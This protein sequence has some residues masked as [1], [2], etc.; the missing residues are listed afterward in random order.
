M[1]PFLPSKKILL[2][3]PPFYRFFNYERWHYPSTLTLVGTYLSKLGHDVG[4][5][6]ADA[7]SLNCKSL[8]RSEV[9]NNYPLYENALKN[10]EHPVWREVYE[11][12]KEFQPDIVGMTSI[13]A[14]I[15]S[16]NFI[17][18]LV[19][20]L[21]D[22]KVKII[23]GGPHA[24]GM[25][26]MYPDYN[27]G[28][29]YD[30]IITHIPNLVDQT[31]NKKLIM[32]IDR[33]SPENLSSILTIAGCP[34]KCTFC[35]RSFD[36]TFVYRN[37]PSVREELEEI[38]IE[39]GSTSVYI[40]DDCFF[41]HTTRFNEISEILKEVGLEFRAGSRIMALTQQKIERFINNGGIRISVGVESGSQQILD[42]VKK[43]L[44]IK[45]IIKHTKW[46][47]DLGVPWSAFIIV[48]FPFETLEELKLTEELIYTIGPTFASINRFAPYPGTEIY[49]KYFINAQIRFRDLF[50]LNQNSCVRLSDEIEDYIDHM[51]EVFDEYNRKPQN[52]WLIR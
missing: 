14:K 47:N 5:Y 28:A 1:F 52:D 13:T 31:P 36:R 24:Y 33:Y 45:E 35:A 30:E 34:M 22:N 23:L 48:G 51:F 4:I 12:I 19:R 42:R 25:R 8:N 27:F 9:R 17:A 43:G 49:K 10:Q 38:R 7:P 11:T 37:I 40:M 32:N 39:F 20:K 46:L 50:Q 41:S 21:Y 16:A 26:M 3:E 6:D 18:K 29:D 15:D 44:K 2:I